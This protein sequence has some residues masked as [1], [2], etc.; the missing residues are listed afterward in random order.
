MLASISIR[1][2]TISEAKITRKL[3]DPEIMKGILVDGFEFTFTES[4]TVMDLG[5]GPP[6]SDERVIVSRVVFPTAA[7]EG[8]IKGLTNAWEDYKKATTKKTS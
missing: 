4:Y 1:A 3:V 6:R 7:M 2:M 5:I 8:L